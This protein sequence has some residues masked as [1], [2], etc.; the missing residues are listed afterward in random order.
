MKKL[1]LLIALSCLL[2][3]NSLAQASS[4]A[5]SASSSSKLELSSALVKAGSVSEKLKAM[6]IKQISNKKSGDDVAKFLQSSEAM[7]I[8]L[9]QWRLFAQADATEATLKTQK[10]KQGEEFKKSEENY[11]KKLAEYQ[12]TKNPTLKSGLVT[13]KASMLDQRARSQEPTS[14]TELMK[15]AKHAARFADLSADLDWLQGMMYSGEEVP[16]LRAVY[17]FLEIA[18]KDASVL[19]SGCKR[20]IASAIALEFARND[21]PTDRAL[22]RAEFYLKNW[23]LG[24]MNKQ[25]DTL[26][27]SQMRVLMGIKGHHKAGYVENYE[28]CLDNAHIPASHYVGTGDVY[29]ICWRGTYRKY[30]IYGDSIHSNFYETYDNAFDTYGQEICLMGAICGGLSHFGAYAAAANGLPAQTMGEP[31]HCAYTV[32]VDGK[33]CPAYSLSWERWLHWYPWQDTGFFSALQFSYDLYCDKNFKKTMASMDLESAALVMEEK[34]PTIA[35]IIYARAIKEQPLN[36]TA[37]RSYFNFLAKNGQEDDKLAALREL[38]KTM[39]ATAPEMTA[40][41]LQS[42]GMALLDG[43]APDKKLAVV[44]DFWQSIKTVGPGNWNI[45]QFITKQADWVC[46]N[47][48]DPASAGVT[49]Y[50]KLLSSVVTK[51]DFTPAVMTWGNDW[52]AKQGQSTQSA[53]AQETVKVIS[54]A[55]GKGGSVDSLLR[56]ALISA[57]NM[58]DISAFNSL[59]KNVPEKNRYA[60]GMPKWDAFAGELVSKGG[61]ISLSSTCEHDTPTMHAGILDP[62]GGKFHT[63][64]DKDAWVRVQLPYVCQISGIV[65][66]PTTNST[67]RQQNMVVQVSSTGE[68]GSWEDV[69]NLGSAAPDRVTRVDMSQNQK[70]ALYVRI[71]RVGGPEFFHLNGIYVYGKRV[72]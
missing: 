62:R 23:A 43:A 11:K 51:P 64:K 27:M 9:A 65:I 71:K 68:D 31:G 48:Q 21:W 53:M 50:S 44:S 22:A 18:D 2:T 33:W 15:D 41:L 29:A 35:N 19:K 25:M 61:I 5:K 16:I 34:N 57:E 3:S 70:K 42:K 36:F 58:G 63:G 67:F 37:Y 59:M 54:Q 14:F 45:A 55:S 1:S 10:T 49:F 56:G 47:A 4:S 28:W 38:C 30:N 32:L 66:I 52:A 13:L 60:G 46:K 8:R 26:S 20:R 24:R 12:S 6:C 7:C 40:F 69:K 39:P 17:L 72:S